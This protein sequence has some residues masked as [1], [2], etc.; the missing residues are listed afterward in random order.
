MQK[1]ENELF[2][3]SSVKSGFCFH[4]MKDKALY[5][6]KSDR[7]LHNLLGSTK[8]NYVNWVNYVN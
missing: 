7:F 4:F 1:G 6:H 5:F 8:G 2:L 3:E